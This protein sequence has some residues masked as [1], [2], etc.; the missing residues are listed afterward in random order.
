M[1]I[2][3]NVSQAS[4]TSRGRVTAASKCGRP[5]ANRIRGVRVAAGEVDWRRNLLAL[6][7]ASFTGIVGITALIP[8]VALFLTR[9]LGVRDPGQLALW[10]GAATAASGLGQAVAGPIWG[11]LG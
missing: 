2:G 9:D 10:T 5:D 4:A 7:I 6:W 1:A 3:R 11:V 8:F